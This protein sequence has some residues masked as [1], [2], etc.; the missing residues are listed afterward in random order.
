MQ[1]FSSTVPEHHVIKMCKWRRYKVAFLFSL[2]STQW[3]RSTPVSL[4]LQINPKF[5]KYGL[6][7]PQNISRREIFHLCLQSKPHHT[8][9][10]QQWNTKSHWTAIYKKFK[11]LISSFR[12]IVNVASFLLSDSSAS[13]FYVP[14]FR[15]T[16]FN[17]HRLFT[18]PMKC[19]ERSAHKIQT[20]QNHPRERIQQ[21]NLG[22]D[23][24]Y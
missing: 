2:F 11:W 5:T 4:Q 16:L 15:N 8:T 23:V 6:D 13:E 24:N 17:L 12:R 3:S 10:S 9:Q 7:K 19:S 20:P 18:W 1:V 22:C 14:M 21:S